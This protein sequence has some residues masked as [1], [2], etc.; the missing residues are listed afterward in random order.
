MLVRF[1][2]Y[3]PRIDPEF[4]SGVW[5]RGMG[6]ELAVEEATPA[7]ADAPPR[8]PGELFEDHSAGHLRR[9]AYAVGE[10]DRDLGDLLAMLRDS[11]CELH[12]EEVAGRVGRRVVDVLERAR[13]PGSEAGGEI[14]RL[15]SEC[16]P[17]VEVAVLGQK[18]AIP[19][20]VG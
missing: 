16:E 9:A 17:R 18:A 20:P 6:A 14:A 3:S 8:D 15:Q 2:G 13:L 10:R 11:V 12:L 19:G 7:V 5:A 1:W 4:E